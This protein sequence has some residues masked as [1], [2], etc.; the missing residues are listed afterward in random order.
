MIGT[1][2]E[3]RIQVQQVI[4]S[5][6]PEFILSESPNTVDFLKQYYISQEHRGGVIDLSDNLD[7]YI[8]LDN[9][10]PEVIVGVTTL[11]TGLTTT[12]DT[13][14]VSSTKGY[15]NEYGLLKIDDEVITYTGITTNSFTGCIR[16]FSGITSYRDPNN[17]GE[18]IFSNT[19]AA[20]HN[21][22]APVNNLSVLFLQEFYKKVKSTFTPGLEDTKFIPNID[23]SNFIKES[24]SLYQSKGTAESFRIL[25]NVLYGITPKIIDTEEF[26]VKPSG[27]EYVRREIILTEVLS[28]DPNKLVGQTITKSND[29]Q[30]NASVSEVEI[31]TR[32]RK[33]YYKLGLFVGFN[34]RSGINGIFTIPGK[35]KVIDNVSVGSSVI[36][37]D[38]T[39]GFGTTGTVVSGINT[40]TYGDKTLNQFLNCTGITSAISTTDDIRSDEFVFGYENGDINKKVEL[41]ITG[42]LSN[43]ELLASTGSSV[44]TEGERITVK[45]LGEVIQNPITG[46]TPKEVF[47]NSWIYNTS[48]SFHINKVGVSTNTSVVFFNSDVDKSNL[49][50]NDKADIIK[51]G[52]AQQVVLSGV[53]VTNITNQSDGTIKI[54]LDNSIFIDKDEDYSLRRKV[55]RAFSSV[56]QLQFGNNVITANVQ[57]TYNQD[58]ESY[59][60]ASSSLPS[61]DITETVSKSTI[62]GNDPSELQGF[63]NL[64]QKFSIIA[65]P[66]PHEFRT[67]DAIFYKA[68]NNIMDGLTEDV[69]YVERITNKK[70][71]LY[72]SRSFIPISDFV[73]FK[74]DGAGSHSFVL[75]RHKN[76]NIGVQKILKKFPAVPN[77]KSGIGSITNPGTT[78]ILING[79]EIVNYKSLD[80]IYFGPLDEVK[81]LNGGSNYDVI[82]LPDITLPQVGSGVTAL[83]RPVIKGTLSEILV[84]QQD[85]DIERILSVSLTGGNGADA[86]IEPVVGRRFRELSF[87]GR[88]S[89]KNGGLDIFNDQIIFTKPHN[90]KDGEPLVYDND[91]FP[92]IGIATDSSGNN[93]DQGVFLADGSVYYPKVVG[94][95]SVKLFATIN[96]FNAGINT[97]GFTTV[98]NQGVHKFRFFNQKNYL[99]SVVIKNK[100]VNY[101]NRKLFVKP[102]GIST[103]EN[104]VT[105]KNHGFETGEIIKYDFAS[106]GTTISGLSNSNQ[107]YI[108]KLDN[109]TFRLANAGADGS[110][111]SNFTRKNYVRFTSFGSGLQEFFYPE[112]TVNVQAVYSPTTLTRSDDL[113][114]TPVVRGSVLNTYLYESGTNYGSDILNFEKDPGVI[115][116]NGKDAEIKVVA[117][118]GKIITADVR[119]GG[120]EYFSPPDLEFVGVGS[121]IGAKLRPVVTNGK[122]TDVK[123]INPGIGYTESPTVLVKPA[124]IGLI[125]KPSVRSLTVNNLERFD[126]EILL[127]ESDTNLQY[128]V[129]GYNTSL[130]SSPFSDPNPVNGHSPIVGWAY[131]GN[132]IY[133]P[134]GYSDPDDINSSIKVI[135]TSYQLNTSG[136]ANRPASTL[137]A[138]GFFVEDFIFNESGDLDKSNGRFCKTPEY[139]NGVYAYFVGVATAASGSLEPK[140]PYFIGDTYRS[141]PIEDNFLINQNNFDLN[142][143]NLIRNTL[144]YKVSD[145][146]AD[147][148]FISESN[149]IIEQ[150]AIIESVTEGNVEGFQIVESGSGF[151]VNDSLTFDNSNTSGGGASA[152]VSKVTGKPI[153]NINTT[154]QTYD[155]VVFVRDSATQVSGFISTSHNF[156]QND[157]IAISGLTTSIPHLTDSF[158]VGVSSESVVLY[159]ALGANATAGVVTDIYV[160]SIPE[161]ISI[162]SSIGIGTE[163]LQVINKFDDRK[164]LRVRRGIVGGSGHAL[165]DIVSTVP[166]KFTIEFKTDPFNSKI[167]EKVFFNPKEQ[168]GLALTAGTVV[169]MAKSFTTGEL[170]KVISVPAKSIFLPNHPFTNNQ[171]LTLK[172]PT[173]AGVL[174]VGTGVTQAV[175]ASFN[176]TDGTTVFAKRISNDL[177]GLSTIRGEETIFF[178]NSPTDNFEYSLETNH[179]QVLG[180]VE[181]II[182]KVTLTTAHGLSN[183]EIIDL[184]LDSNI[185]GGTG[186]STSV[187]VKYSS[188]EDKLLINPMSLVQSNVGTDR[189][190]KDD[191]GFVTGQ[192]VYYDITSGAVATGLSS[193]RSY[194]IYRIDDDSFQLGETRYDVINEPPKII[195]IQTNTGG[196]GQELSLIN[197]PL[198]IVNNDDLVF[199]VGDSSL[200]GLDLKFYYDSEFK[201]EF[202]SGGSTTNFAITQQGVIGAGGTIILNYNSNNPVNL[203]YAVDKSGFISTS[204]TDVKDGNKI[205]YIDSEYEG[206]YS[207]FG[208]GSTSFNISLRKIP[209][210][211]TYTQSNTDTLSYKTSSSNAVGGIG[212]LNLASGGFGYKKFPGISS[213]TTASGVNSKVLALSQSINKINKV[214]ILDPGFEYHSDKTLRPEARISPTITLINSDVISDIEILSGGQDYLSVPD[215]VVVD[216][217]TGLLTDQGV[218]ELSLTSSSISSVKIFSTPKG[219]KPIEQRLRT[220]NNSNGINVNTVVGMANSTSTGI[221]TCTLVTPIGGFNPAPFAVGDKIFVEGIQLHPDANGDLIGSGYNSTDYGYDFFEITDYQNTSPAKLEFSLVGLSTAVGIAKTSQTNYATIINFNKYPQ[222]RSIQKSSEFRVG[223][224]L[225]IKFNNRFV[226]EDLT[227]LEN[228]PDDFI[229][230]FGSKKLKVGDL[231]RGEITGTVATINTLN[232]N[233]GR[234]NIDYSLEKDQGWNTEIG[235]LSEDYQVLPDNDYYQNLAYTIQSSQTF[236]EI[237]D[238]V[239]RLIH[240]SGLKNFSD[241]VLTSKAKSGIS[242]ISD[243]VIG[244]DVISEERVDTINNFDFVVDTDNIGLTQSKFLRLQSTKLSDFIQC[245]TNRVLDIDDFSNLFSN[246]NSTL[247]GKV[248]V[249]I[250]AD[251]ESFV[252]QTENPSTNEIQV[253]ELVIYKDNTDTFTFEKN[254]LG[255]GTQTIVDFEG[256]ADSSTS[257]TFLRITP[258]NVFDDD[259]DIKIYRSRFNSTTAGINTNSIG[260]INLVGVAKTA[261]PSAT[262]SLVNG[263]VGVTS[264]FYATVEVTDNVTN[265][266]NVVD[267]YVTH[268]GTDS[269]FS[270][271][272]ADSGSLDNLS[273]NFI[274]TFTS[275]LSSGVLSIDFENTG[276]NTATLRSKVVGFGTTTAGIGTFRFK[277]AAQSAGNERTVNLQSSFKRVSSTSTLVGVDSNKFSTIKSIVKVAVGSTI[278][279]HQ[280]LATHN[281]TDTSVV[282]YPFISIGS[283]AGIGTFIANFA[284]N[285]FNLRFNPDT[286]V[287]DAEVSAY[288]EVFYTDL[289]LFNTPPD[290]VYGRVTENVGVTLYNAVNGNRSNKTEFDLKHNNIPI[291]AKTFNPSDNNIVVAATGEFL[292]KDHFF[293]TGEKLKYTPKSTFIGV[294]A[295]SMET[296]PG[297]DLP[298]D[299]FAIRDNSDKFRLATSLSNANAGTAVTFT[300]LGAGNAHQLEMTKKLEKSL[301]VIDG[302]IQSPIAFTP[303]NTTLTNNGGSISAT[304]TFASIAGLSSITTSDIL[305]IDDEFLKVTAVGLGTLA[306]GPITGTGSF[307]LVSVERGA[308]GTIAASHN[309]NT[310]VRKF[311]GSFNIVDS[312][313]HFTDPPKGSNITKRDASNSI[314][315]RS[316][317]HGR[318][319][320]RQSYDKNRIFDDISD[321]FTGVGATHLMKVAGANATGIQTGGSIVLLNG[322]FQTPTT[323]NNQGN[324]YDF[325][326]DTT[327]GITTVTFTGITSA[328]GQRIVSETDVNLNQLPRGGMIVSLG[329][330]GGLGVAPLVGAAVTA[331]KNAN[332]T[333]TSVGLSTSDILGSGYRGTVAV[334]VTDVA[335]EHRFVS[336]GIGSIKKAAFS[337]AGSQALTATNAEYTSHT[338]ILVLTI[339][340]HGLTTS[341]TVGIDT[342]GI[343]FSCSKD[344]FAT[345]HPYPRAVSKT[346]GLPDPIA[347]IQTAITAVTTNTITIDVH[348]G[349]G[350]G[351]GANITATVGAGGTLA[352]T[353]VSGGTGYVNPQ[354][355]VEPPTYEN[356]DVIGVSRLGIGPTTATGFG[357]KLTVDVDAAPT[358]GIGSTLHQVSSFKVASTGF[359]FKKGDVIRPVGLVTERGLSTKVSDF[360]LTVTEVFT[361][362]FASWDFGEFDFIDP[363]T[364]FIDGVRKRFP[365]KL[366][367]EFLSFE[368]NNSNIDSSLI[369]ME[370]LLLIFINGV[371]QEPGVAY[372]FEGGTT[373]GFEVPPDDGD[374]VSVFFYKGTDGV[375][376]NIVDVNAT[377]KEGDVVEVGRG[378]GVLPQTERTIVGITTSDTFET[379]LYTGGGIDPN[380]FRPIVN[381]RK[382]KIDKI[383]RGKVVSKARDSIEPLIFPTARIIG[384]L[385]TSNASG[386]DIFVDDAQFFN[387][388]EN[389]STIVIDTFG[390][391]IVN[392]VDQVSAAL[393]ATVSAAG[394]ISAITVVDGGSGYVGSTT[395]VNIAAPVGVANTLFAKVGVS[396]YATATA[397]ITNGSIASVAVNNIGLGYTSSNPPAVI[398]PSPLPLSEEL[399]GIKDVSGFKGTITGISTLTVGVSTV[400]L[401]FGLTRDGSAALTPDLKVGYP[402]YIFDTFVGNGVTSLNESGNSNDTV[403]IGT[404]FLDNVYIIKQIIGS[405]SSIEIVTNVHSGINTAGIN[406]ASA[407]AIT[408]NLAVTANANV[409]YILN[410]TDRH[411]AE[412]GQNPTLTIQKGDILIFTNNMN[413]HPL[414][415]KDALGN[416]ATGAYNTGVTNNGQQNGT[417]T[418]NTSS[419]PA[420]IYYY[421][422]GSH[423]GMNGIINVVQNVPKGSFS[424]GRFSNDSTTLGRDKPVAI[425]VTGYTV[426]LSTGVGISTFP[427]IQRKLFGL[428]DTGAVRKDLP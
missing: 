397:T 326:G 79:V 296:A 284:N 309:D 88:L 28:G 2:I 110:D 232:N 226:L 117:S 198:S 158:K 69:Y 121:G 371:L 266:K 395:S 86:I 265:E 307:K 105:F 84:D 108:I 337:G 353:V 416:G 229:K 168:V 68:S 71:R 283:T 323:S 139:P 94:I 16:G 422:C 264:A 297:T 351:T 64:T 356:L 169:S 379:D 102:V 424:W 167:N 423:Y 275:N 271:Y 57:N 402:I 339:P 387:Y 386:T 33:T 14:K 161:R 70:I 354:I 164:I 286:G 90:L 191:H 385:S 368:I 312:K 396:T 176:L 380:T 101:T 26:L 257:D 83:V 291:F 103:I 241:T 289:D 427:T 199:Y 268:D 107:Y 154:V 388:E 187:I 10:T 130:L 13:I 304:D 53:A 251:Y 364:P 157:Q 37:V 425:G 82:N 32:D 224:R 301:I 31:V 196:S 35:S 41:R 149:E 99:K 56:S 93:I 340:N 227:V 246:T 212:A 245:L 119:F 237:S 21:A 20:D 310:A 231:I 347:G 234:F 156:T 215:L 96:D 162:G 236:A 111:N 378:G 300:S 193:Q 303:I 222:F 363:I 182:S 327:A 248:D 141:T 359:G 209:E 338:G 80:K 230:V 106:G 12:T 61:Y 311:K 190:F 95:T 44:T 171:Q 272:Y 151:K 355:D 216:P 288:S 263:E 195:G 420:G 383:I 6:L 112:I 201:N 120:K 18:L 334:G 343:V 126:D 205:N 97:V 333:I 173:G 362:N 207:V 390:A 22:D 49:K 25:F 75:L 369:K 331:L 253:N 293:N 113:V 63:S 319:Y 39:V 394:T 391:Q 306:V 148:D 407:S 23:V 183:S 365:I 189:I 252:I 335:Y 160:S 152:F 317:F 214:R 313:I 233:R 42:V 270:E 138:D 393:T 43:F 188:V 210:K 4:E 48:S 118:K 1:G 66:N 178:K 50:I 377:L 342:G 403:G 418:W 87:D 240:T 260:F 273:N 256:I 133:G 203:F 134:Y 124:G 413:A 357:L 328:N 282:H 411:G 72:T 360:E 259:L 175:A 269:Y 92:S 147:N 398:A 59:Y 358:T 295:D 204:D 24:K 372:N 186:V 34:E 366:N 276:I 305:K 267:L 220:I 181:K 52:G 244:R 8:K 140:F 219:L 298:T 336:S 98:N 277:D 258:T 144:P 255:I 262:I 412:T 279:M 180:K 308:L 177:V 179:T 373:F 290:F 392:N 415:I 225:G 316:D 254:Q 349:G 29:S 374:D 7:Q 384:D 165:S 150:S 123:I 315:P 322:I 135:D 132:P 77:I 129:V 45:N 100:G 341:D 27:A 417:L 30:T 346:T 370:N 235:K 127:K 11:T 170:S 47:F 375:D 143:N 200:S 208:I 344:H 128:A 361:D 281:G 428:R 292:I 137:F 125:F 401:K 221:V 206:S 382:Q 261:D 410:G 352:F 325:T 329:S 185:S 321:G 153:L 104:T 250:L 17:P 324:N 405:G 114:L 249:P 421:Q 228:N 159:K 213:V 320:L 172:I 350:G 247:S 122:I 381:W 74:L 367:G 239:N 67:G 136:V 109:D 145:P 419:V 280:V 314:I 243:L 285:K 163:K 287:T 202:V 217:E 46:K 36:T 9:L 299:V 116:K 278:A 91:G 55:D 155:D 81:I 115:V 65:F 62:T 174:S 345:L 89:T 294:T 302:L 408:F 60:V 131:D 376:T 5:Q 19:T 414:Y 73:E 400:G 54:D 3:K 184:T 51:R 146:D 274:G 238:P 166:H 409:A 223:E 142:S 348:P 197:P 406:L 192:K 40:I 242:S 211:L 426:G 330:T 85:F 38:S 76:E 332:G 218:I 15:P 78:G 389:E 194:Y 404:L 58:E 399:T 318:V